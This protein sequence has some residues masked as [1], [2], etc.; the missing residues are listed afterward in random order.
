MIDTTLLGNVLAE[1]DHLRIEDHEVGEGL[2]EQP[3][4]VPLARVF[5]QL[6]LSAE[7]ARALLHAC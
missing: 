6:V 4:H 1:D 5:G 2:A 3:G 7:D